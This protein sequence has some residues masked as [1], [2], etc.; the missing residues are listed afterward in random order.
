[1]YPQQN[2]RTQPHGKMKHT[3]TRKNSQSCVPLHSIRLSVVVVVVFAR[4]QGR[5]RARARGTRTARRAQDVRALLRP[6]LA[7]QM[8][9][10]H[11]WST[12]RVHRV[13]APLRIRRIFARASGGGGERTIKP[14]RSAYAHRCLRVLHRMH[15]AGI[16]VWCSREKNASQPITPSIWY[17]I[18]RR[19][20]RRTAYAK[21]VCTREHNYTTHTKV[22]SLCALLSPE[23]AHQTHTHSRELPQERGMCMLLLCFR[24]C[25]TT[26]RVAVAAVRRSLNFLPGELQR[27]FVA[28]VCVLSVAGNIAVPRADRVQK[29][30]TPPPTTSQQH[31]ESQHPACII[32]ASSRPRNRSSSNSRRQ[33]KL[34][35]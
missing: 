12:V 17:N 16:V 33:C 10:R 34:Y 9:Q 25:T 11:R 35:M 30:P 24:L 2:V 3:H 5:L 4:I 8:H 32:C 19:R 27:V 7:P 14:H 21:F 20:R 6:S 29:N 13:C 15:A 1:M 26:R 31:P 28:C 18:R 22:G 23:H